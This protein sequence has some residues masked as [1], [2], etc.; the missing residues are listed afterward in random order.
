MIEVPEGS[1]SEQEVLSILLGATAWAAG[2][3][4]GGK[5]HRGRLYL[6][7]PA[8]GEPPTPKTDQEIVEHAVDAFVASRHRPIQEIASSADGGFSRQPRRQHSLR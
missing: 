4:F 7:A 3:P 8:T 5:V 6:E 2:L 1:I